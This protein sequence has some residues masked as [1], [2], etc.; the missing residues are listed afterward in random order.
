MWE[1]RREL[2]RLVNQLTFREQADGSLV[3]KPE[4]SRAAEDCFRCRNGLLLIPHPPRN[5]GG[6]FH[7]DQVRTEHLIRAFLQRGR[8]LASR[9]G[10]EPFGGD[11][12]VEH[13][14]P[15]ASRSSRIRAA[16]S[17][18]M[19]YFS[20]IALRSARISAA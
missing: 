1:V 4:P 10:E 11:A 2:N 12:G 6:H 18:K 20:S 3:Q 16:L 14:H 17:E 8:F 7:A 15:R 9:L 5:G 19:P 13:D